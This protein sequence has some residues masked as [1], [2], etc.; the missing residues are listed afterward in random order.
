MIDDGANARWKYLGA[1]VYLKGTQT[2]AL[3]EYEILDVS[4]VRV[5][6]IGAVTEETP[7]LVSPAGVTALDFGDPVAAVNRVAGQ[8]TDGDPANGEAEVLVAE[9]HEGAGEGSP[10]GATLEE[11]VAAGGAF[12]AIVI[13]T[14]PTVAAIFTGHTH[15]QYAWDGPVPGQPGR[16][17]PILQTGSYGENVG[18]IVL[19]VDRDTNAVTAY[20]ATNV[21]RVTTADDELVASYPR[22]AQVK[23]IVDAAIAGGQ[24]HRSDAGRYGRRRHHHRLHRRVL[25]ERRVRPAQS[26]RRD[27]RP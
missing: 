25:R 2:P 7:S 23:G 14:S 15:Q 16:T 27:D 3:P 26:G 19:T 22:V 24:R 18:K 12:A 10:D 4:G 11:A 6:V 17:R 9:Y 13:E 1:N 8:L 21:A 20:T 5:G